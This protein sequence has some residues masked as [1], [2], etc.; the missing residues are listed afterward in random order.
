VEILVAGVIN[1]IYRDSQGINYQSYAADSD[2]QWAEGLLVL[3]NSYSESA[4]A[5]A[6]PVCVVRVHAPF[7]TRNVRFHAS[8]IGTPPVVPSRQAPGDQLYLGGSVTL[9]MPQ[10]ASSADAMNW[11]ISGVWSYVLTR[12]HIPEDGIPSVAYPFDTTRD[13][14]LIPQIGGT[15][16]NPPPDLSQP[17][18]TYI[19]GLNFPGSFFFPLVGSV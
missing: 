15:N 14:P 13:N 5:D 17:N 10:I 12:S 9:P 1:N 2:V 8:K 18:Y 7:A 4:S 19:D 16:E 3:P 6:A 11:K